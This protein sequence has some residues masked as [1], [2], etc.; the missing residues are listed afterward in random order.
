VEQVTLVPDQRPV[1]ELT[2][3]GQHPPFHHRVHP[4]HP[5]P[6]QHRLDSG[7]GQDGV[8]QLR[9][10][11]VPVADQEACPGSCRPEGP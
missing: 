10:P 6:G 5:H 4:R 7:I 1:Q 11:A 9:E 3:A 2:P 8:E